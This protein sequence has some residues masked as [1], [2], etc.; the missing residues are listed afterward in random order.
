MKLPVDVAKAPIRN[1][2]IAITKQANA[3]SKDCAFVCLA[4]LQAKTLWKYT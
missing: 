4:V 3:A 1:G 2:G